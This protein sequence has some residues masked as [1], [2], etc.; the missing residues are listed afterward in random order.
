MP[1]IKYTKYLIAV[2]ILSGSCSFAQNTDSISTKLD[3]LKKQTDST[4]QINLVEPE[5]YNEKTKITPKVFGILLLS[6]FKQ[7]ALSPFKLNKKRLVRDAVIL[8]VGVGV[9]FLDKPI[10]K[11]GVTFRNN[12]PW[13]SSYSK[14][15]SDIGGSFEIV[16]LA[17]IAATGFITKNEK[18]KTTTALAVQ[19]YTTT[20]VWT[21]VLKAAFGRQRPSNFDPNSALN[22]PTFNG[23]FYEFTKGDNG[24]FPS[25]HAALAFAAATVYAKEYKNIP[26]IPIISYTLAG[27]ITFSRITQNKHW[28]TDLIAGSLLGFASGTQVVNNYHRYA[29]LKRKEST[30]GKMTAKAQF[31][32]TLQYAY[33]GGIQP[34]FIYRF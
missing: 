12:N 9:A 33:G 25:G 30:K 22:R 7:Q 16:P 11:W 13:S 5:F 14:A 3:S 29:R 27:L 8:G 32:W 23:P 19:S 31:T 34:G 6:D 18:L 10:Q 2:L 4:G 28:A 21:Y 26:A 1:G 15:V 20:S 24:A 17:A